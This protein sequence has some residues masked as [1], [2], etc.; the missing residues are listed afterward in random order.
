PD[1]NS[2]TRG[3]DTQKGWTRE[4]G[5]NRSS[6]INRTA[7]LAGWYTPATDD[8]PSK[9][10]GRGLGNQVALMVASLPCAAA[11]ASGEPSITCTAETGSIGP[12]NPALSL[13]LNGFPPSW[14]MALKSA[15][16]K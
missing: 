5:A 16:K 7:A 2:A 8:R 6:T 13:W 4:S 12:L 15:S 10:Q 9:N 11:K 3:A 14:L 1:A